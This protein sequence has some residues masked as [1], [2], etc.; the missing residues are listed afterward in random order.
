MSTSTTGSL[1]VCTLNIRGLRGHEAEV[2]D[3]FDRQA[4]DILCLQEVMLL[5]HLTITTE[6]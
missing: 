3:F 6:G 2:N 1:K 4:L 5:K